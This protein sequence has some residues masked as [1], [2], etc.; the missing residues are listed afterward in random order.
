MHLAALRYLLLLVG[1]LS[2]LLSLFPS[3]LLAQQP[4]ISPCLS[5]ASA[6]YSFFSIAYQHDESLPGKENL[7]R[8]L[9][10]PS[11]EKPAPLPEIKPIPERVLPRK[12]ILEEAEL[13]TE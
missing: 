9:T 6:S 13:H 1:C 11:L 4:T 2:L 3:H 8:L 7:D 10:E 5:T 12:K